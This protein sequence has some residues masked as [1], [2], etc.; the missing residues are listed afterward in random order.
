MKLLN[1]WHVKQQ[2]REFRFSRSRFAKMSYNAGNVCERAERRISEQRQKQIQKRRFGIVASAMDRHGHECR[3][4]PLDGCPSRAPHTRGAREICR[5]SP[6]VEARC[7]N[8][9][10]R[11]LCGGRY[12]C[13]HYAMKKELRLNS[14]V[15]DD[16]RRIAKGR[17]CYR[18]L[19]NR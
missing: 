10:R 4:W 16:H 2:P 12:R 1:A 11:D 9:A 19:R 17:T 7:P 13:R 14:G 3:A 15:V 18:A 8:W 5:H 6:T